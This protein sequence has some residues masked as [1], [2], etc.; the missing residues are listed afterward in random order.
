MIASAMNLLLVEHNPEDADL[1]RVMLDKAVSLPFNVTHVVSLDDAELY[2]AQNAVDLILLDLD[3]AGADRVNAIRRTHAA[4]PGASLVVLTG[5]ENELLGVQA[6][7]EGA[8]DYLVKGQIEARELLRTLRYAVERRNIEQQL[9]VA[10]DHAEAAQTLLHDAVQSM[11]EGF[12]IY[13]REDRFVLCNEACRQHYR[14]SADLLAPGTSFEDILQGGAKGDSRDG[15]VEWRSERLRLHRE[16]TGTIELRSRN[17]SW[18]LIS[19]RRMQNGG[20]A[21]LRVDITALKQA[22]AA[23]RESEARLDRAQ[24]I[25]GIGSWE[26][27]LITGRYLWSRQLYFICGLSPQE[28]E[29]TRDNIATYVHPDDCASVQL[30]LSDLIAGREADLHEIRITCPDGEIRLGRIEGR[31]VSGTDGLIR[32]LAGTFQDITERRLIER[33][34]AQAQKMEAIGKLTGGLAHDFNNGLAVI[35]GNLDLL[36]RLVKADPTAAELC[37][38]ARQGARRCADLIRSLLAF[39]RQQPLRPQRTDVNQL[40]RRTAKLLGGTLGG[41]I[42]LTL[43]WKTGCQQSLLI[44]PSLRRL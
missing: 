41:D 11:S 35:T 38:D 24:A 9:G 22:Q 2:L 12:V 15:E 26:L 33:Q 27:D 7:Q 43:T 8:Q 18:L 28:F 4:A 42:S 21:G 6:S 29:P 10:N 23:L 16:A 1:L 39:A 44:L 34:L 17:G 37:D 19:D 5:S 25:A 31:A 40:V 30:W 32:K 14:G 13:D 3:L 20:I 36:A